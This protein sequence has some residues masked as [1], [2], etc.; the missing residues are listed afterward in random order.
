MKLS[1]LQLTRYVVTSIGCK[2]NPQF[3]PEKEI[4]GALEHFSVDV[5]LNALP[6][7]KDVPGHSWSLELDIVQK[8]NHDQTFPYEFHLSLLGIFS[9][10]EGPDQEKE[11]R[12]VQVNGSSTLYGMA[13]EHIRAL[14]AG[15]PWGAIILPTVSFYENKEQP[16]QEAATTKSQPGQ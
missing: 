6:P 3:N 8:Q 14:T 11:T 7:E 1:P 5:R 13:R 15:G 2:A 9:I 10:Q 16:K 12:F 4:G